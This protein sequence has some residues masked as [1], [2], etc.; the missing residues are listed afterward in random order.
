MVKISA[1]PKCWIRELSSGEMDLFDWIEQSRVLACDGLEIYVRF[2]RRWDDTYLRVVRERVEDYGM[3]I[4]MLCAS[5]DFTAPEPQLQK[6]IAR[7]NEYIV[8]TS[9]LGG[10]YCRVL[11]GQRR[12]D[13]PREVGVEQVVYC[14]EECLK[15]AR[16][17]GVTLVIENH[18]KDDHWLY[19]EFAQDQETF[20]QILDRIQDSA[21]GVQYDPS[22]AIVGGYDPLA[23][24]DVV[25]PRVRTMHAS[26]R[27]V[28]P[29]FDLQTVIRDFN[30]QGYHPALRHGVVGEGLND[31]EAIFRRLSMTGFDGWISIED[32]ING[33]DEMKRSV[34]FLR[35]LCARH[36]GRREQGRKSYV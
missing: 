6:E 19:P 25:A 5:P 31:Y 33:M 10:R 17:Y 2:F 23:L 35:L 7:Q 27:Y 9:Q 16:R 1:F 26:D 13:L 22:N 12:P 28:E 21:F 20:L 15:T 32:G 11:S 3:Q 18:Y 30:R 4:P 24:L 14:I 29:G 8:A 36:F 34:N